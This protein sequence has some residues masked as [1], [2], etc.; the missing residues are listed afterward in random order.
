MRYELRGKGGAVGA[1]RN[2]GRREGREVAEDHCCERNYKLSIK[3]NTY[4][5]NTKGRETAPGVSAM[6]EALLSVAGRTARNQR[7]IASGH[8]CPA[9]RCRSPLSALARLRC[10][11]AARC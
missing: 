6:D 5:I 9:Q 11:L 3:S 1:R 10:S 4:D 8:A 7:G 2:A